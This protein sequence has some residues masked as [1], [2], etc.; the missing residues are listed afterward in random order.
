MT[1]IFKTRDQATEWLRERGVPT[2]DSTLDVLAN[3]GGGPK[4]SV[5]NGR[6]LYTEP[7][8]LSW[9]EAQASQ[10]PQVASRRGR[11]ADQVAA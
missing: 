2:S 3:K 11:R 10:P 9:L 8:L 6:A 5:I 7:D 1:L 4:Y